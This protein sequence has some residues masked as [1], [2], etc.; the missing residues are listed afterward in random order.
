MDG[1]GGK[2]QEEWIFWISI[3]NP[4]FSDICEEFGKEVII[5]NVSEHHL[6]VLSKGTSFQ[7]NRCDLR[8]TSQFDFKMS[9]LISFVELKLNIPILQ[10]S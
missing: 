1:S 6:A 2:I 7:W 4:F 10:C 8:W 5:G 9:N 3:S